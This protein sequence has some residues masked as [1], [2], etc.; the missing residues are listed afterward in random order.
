MAKDHSHPGADSNREWVRG[1][2]ATRFHAVCADDAGCSLYSPDGLAP[3]P[4]T[5]TAGAE[6]T[7]TI[8]DTTGTG[9]ASGTRTVFLTTTLTSSR[10]TLTATTTTTRGT[11]TPSATYLPGNNDD[12]GQ[13][14]LPRFSICNPGDEDYR[15]PGGLSLT[16]EQTTTLAT[17]AVMFLVI[18]IGWNFVVIRYL[19][20]PLKVSRAS[21]RSERA[22]GGRE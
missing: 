18:L 11:L 19:F 17:L 1:A 5:I 13:K 6:A 4:T 10:S 12:D 22:R 21:E 14:Y 15:E 9:S 8:W 7:T 16:R 20:Y 2:M 3:T